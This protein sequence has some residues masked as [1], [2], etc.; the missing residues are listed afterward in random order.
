MVMVA[1]VLERDW[2][3]ARVMVASR[4]FAFGVRDAI[5]RLP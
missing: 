1:Y 4:G 2:V 3:F 5:T